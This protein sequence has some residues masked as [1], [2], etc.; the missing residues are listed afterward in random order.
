MSELYGAPSGYRQQQQDETSQAM[1]KLAMQTGE[2]NLEKGELDIQTARMALDRQN[3]M[4]KMMQT[5]GKPGADG[6]TGTKVD[7]ANT[8]ADDMEQMANFALSSGLPKEASD[9][10]TTASTLRNNQ[11]KIADREH[12]QSMK[13][14]GVMDRLLD[15]VVDEESWQEAKHAYTV[16]TGQ[17]IPKQLVDEPYDPD[18][19]THL[20]KASTDAKTE[21]QIAA[22]KAAAQSSL[23]RVKESTLRRD[24]IAAQTREAD[25]RTRKIKK[26]G[27][28]G[29]LAKP[30][31]VRLITDLMQQE[32]AIDPSEELPGAR[33]MAG[34][35]AERMLEMRRENPALSQSAAAKRAYKE[36]KDRGDFGGLETRED[37]T[38]GNTKATP[39]DIP[40]KKGKLD[41]ASLVP[42]K[43]YKGI[44][45][46]AGKTFLYTQ[47]GRFLEVGSGAGQVDELDNV[48]E[49]DEEADSTYDDDE[50]ED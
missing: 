23:A 16:E 27:G 19:I 32:Y 49:E 9:Y 15:G 5:G 43:Y 41:T 34:P 21:A 47:G 39:M 2:Q 46:R 44:G 17:P 28:A 8:L 24:L 10:A 40:V 14:M 25:A 22:S 13:N 33:V 35:V 48:D 37:H 31:D 42:N 7:Q 20:R 26:E 1:A 18:L 6:G 3:A 45:P 30:G 36:A 12:R 38:G 11:S 4:L 29:V 50:S